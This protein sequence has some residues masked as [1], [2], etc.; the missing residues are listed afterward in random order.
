MPVDAIILHTQGSELL[1]IKGTRTLLHQT[2][3]INSTFETPFYCSFELS[4]DF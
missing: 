3:Y 4:V 1:A 2:T